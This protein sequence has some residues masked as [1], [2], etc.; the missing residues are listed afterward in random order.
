MAH[1]TEQEKHH[2]LERTMREANREPGMTLPNGATI[3]QQRLVRGRDNANEYEVLAVVRGYQPYV[4][5]TR[6]IGVEQRADGT[7][8]PLDYCFNG[9]YFHAFHDAIDAWTFPTE[10]DEEEQ[11]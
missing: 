7:H 5:W 10:D 11:S 1:S 3:I 4:I 9:R 6:V 8:G 2:A